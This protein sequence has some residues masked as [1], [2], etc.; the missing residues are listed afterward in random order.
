M[1]NFLGKT[2]NIP[3]EI[4]KSLEKLNEDRNSAITSAKYFMQQKDS[5]EAKMRSIIEGDMKFL[6][7]YSY[8]IDM[9]TKEI[10]ITDDNRKRISGE[11]T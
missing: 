7:D 1:E 4:I 6:A 5:I 10:I 9:D 3:D 2:F 11:N 8:K